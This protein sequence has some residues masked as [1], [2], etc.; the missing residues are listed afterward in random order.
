MVI[1]PRL[2]I[3]GRTLFRL[4][5]KGA[6]FRWIRPKTAKLY[7]RVIRLDFLRQL[8]VDMGCRFCGP[9]PRLTTHVTYHYI[10]CGEWLNCCTV[11][12]LGNPLPYT[13]SSS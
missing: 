5:N 9:H 8:I 2:E 13:I 7:A 10:D 6:L 12:W 11:T 4:E 1:G 3:L